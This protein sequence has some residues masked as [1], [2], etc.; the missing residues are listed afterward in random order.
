MKSPFVRLIITLIVCA[1]AFVGYGVWFAAIAAKSADVANLESEITATIETTSRVAAARTALA[2]IVDDEAVVQSYFVPET[3]VVAF[4]TE[5][6]AS[7]RSQ[8]AVVNVVS[9][10]KAGS[11]A[12][13]VLALALTIKGTFD[14]VMRTVGAIEYAPFALTISELSLRQDAKNG[15]QADLKLQVGSVS[16]NT[17]TSQ[18]NSNALKTTVL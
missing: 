11:L 4:I 1:V 2:K 16:A 14:A 6:E 9:V 12:Q 13:P 18:E 8:D 7:G 3:S 15:W 17:K 10:S 5:L